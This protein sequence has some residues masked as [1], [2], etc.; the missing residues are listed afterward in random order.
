MQLAAQGEKPDAPDAAVGT[1]FTYQGQIKRNG[2]LFTG[3]CAMQFKCGTPA[4]AGAQQGSTLNVSAVAV[5]GGVFTV[6]L[7][8]GNQ[9]KGDA[10]WLETSA[11]CADDAGFTTLPRVAVNPAPY[12]LGL[13]P[14]AQTLGNIPGSGG[15]FRAVNNGP[16]AA[17][18]GLANGSTG[19]TYGVLGNAFSPNGYAVLGYANGGATGV[20]GESDSSGAGVSGRNQQVQASTVK[21][22]FPKASA[23]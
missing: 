5:T 17:L 23:A 9:F 3:T 2:A 22:R 6:R 15:I 20:R 21:A 1:A 18:V 11:K 16:G 7:D 8:F 14:G 19:T 12:A 13:M 4:S 10:R